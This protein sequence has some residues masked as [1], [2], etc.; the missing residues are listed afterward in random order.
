MI[1][2]HKLRVN[3]ITILNNKNVINMKIEMHFINW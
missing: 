1:N 3:T 2:D